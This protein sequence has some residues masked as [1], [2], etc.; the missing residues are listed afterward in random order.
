MLEGVSQEERREGGDEG[1]EKTGVE[2][3]RSYAENSGSS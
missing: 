3:A 1:T 2:S